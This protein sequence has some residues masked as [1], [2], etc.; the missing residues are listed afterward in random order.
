MPV[1]EHQP[2]D[3]KL[4]ELILLIARDSEGDSPFGATKLN[5]LL[6]FADFLAYRQFGKPI[7][8][9]E[10]MRL[11]NGP[12]PRRMVRIAKGM[13]STGQIAISER[14]YFGKPQKVLK[15]LREPNLDRF[16]AREIDL[17]NTLIRQCWGKNATE[18]SASSHRFMGWRLAGEKETI[19]YSVALVSRGPRTEAAER[20]AAALVE[21]AQ[22]AMKRGA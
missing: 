2:D 22:D 13:E 7:T 8:A 11:P 5:K 1:V 12:A 9:Q 17:V 4:R 18:M 10:Y 16:S 21:K 3:D 20:H 15:A 6:F 14:L 19:P